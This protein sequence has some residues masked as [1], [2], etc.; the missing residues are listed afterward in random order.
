MF[1]TTLA[2][3]EDALFGAEGSNAGYTRVM[4]AL[5]TAFDCEFL[6]K[7]KPTRKHWEEF[8]IAYKMLRPY[9]MHTEW[10]PIEEWP[11]VDRA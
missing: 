2:T 7:N 3:Q 10:P 1:L 4:N 5:A 8:G 11:A 9:L 6:T